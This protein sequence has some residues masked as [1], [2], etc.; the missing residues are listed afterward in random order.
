MPVR[1]FIIRNMH[2][3]QRV[4]LRCWT[5]LKVDAAYR[6]GASDKT[7]TT[8]F[9]TETGSVYHKTSDCSHIKLSIRAVYGIPTDLRNDN[10]ARYKPCEACCSEPLDNY[11]GYYITSDGTRFHTIRECS[12]LKRSV[13]EISFSE[14]GNRTPCKRCY[15]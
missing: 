1:I 9:V 15:K 7:E 11:T 3:I 8:V 10:G 12:K 5:G 13:K 4:R 2:F 14:T 6:D